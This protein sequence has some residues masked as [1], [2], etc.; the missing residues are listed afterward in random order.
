MTS[1][2]DGCD[3]MMER[4]SEVL[5]SVSRV[6]YQVPLGTLVFLECNVVFDQVSDSKR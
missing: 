4:C 1:I 5:L 3:V 6:L 2:T